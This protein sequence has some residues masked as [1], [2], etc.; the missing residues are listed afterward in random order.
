MAEQNAELL[1]RAEDL[2]AR[3]EKDSSVTHTLFLTP[4]EQY[5]LSNWAKNRTDCRLVFCG[6]QDNAERKVG[7][8]LPFWFDPE[9]SDPA[10]DEIN[11]VR[12]RAYFGTPG[13]RDYLGSA[14]ALGIKREW[15]GDIII[16]E[17]TAYIVCLPTVVPVLKELDHVGRYGVKAEE[18]P[19]TDVPR[20]KVQTKTV[21]FTVQSSRFDT[22]VGAMF[23]M[24]RT[25]AAKLI[26]GGLAQLNYSE[27]VKLDAEVEEGDVISLRG[28]GKGVLSG[29]GG[30]SRKGRTFLTAEIF[31]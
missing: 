11:A 20:I 1:R 21:T 16:E 27:C 8:F 18:V 4:A 25:A 23:G 12:V 28:Y 26:Q 22:I 9:L 29:T 24:S 3:C 13:H 17:D 7:F 15:L 14:V 19:L 10:E 30:K 31:K 6:G 2:R 5:A